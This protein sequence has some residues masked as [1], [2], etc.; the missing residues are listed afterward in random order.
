VDAFFAS[1]HA[2]S[3]LLLQLETPLETA[4]YAA[5]TAKARGLTVILNPAPA[6]PLPDDIFPYIDVITPNETEAGVLTG[7]DVTDVDAAIQ[8][9]KALCQRGAAHT[10]VT[11]GG[12]GVVHVTGDTARHHPTYRVQ[13]VDTTAAGDAFT[14]AF[15]AA[16]ARGLAFDDAICTGL[17]A[18]AL[19]VTK[20]GAQSS[21][22]TRQAVEELIAHGR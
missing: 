1:G 17:A 22:P 14:G 11:L 4:V 18:G 2:A 15:G 3:V 21:L 13:V 16:L 8:A 7:I 20:L 19:T 6:A 9:G 12:Q 5:K 10:I